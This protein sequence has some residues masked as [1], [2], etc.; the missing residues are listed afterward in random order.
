MHYSL[1]SCLLED[2]DFISEES[3]GGIESLGSHVYFRS[4]LYTLLWLL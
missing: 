4:E 2:V 3:L 1:S